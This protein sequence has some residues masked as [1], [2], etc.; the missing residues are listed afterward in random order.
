MVNEHMRRRK[1]WK[2]LRQKKFIKLLSVHTTTDFL[3]LATNSK[4]CSCCLGKL[5][6]WRSPRKHKKV[7]YSASHRPV[8]DNPAVEESSQTRT[9]V[10]ENTRSTS[11]TNNS[12]YRSTP[13]TLTDV[14]SVIRSTT[15]HSQDR[16][17]Q[18]M[19]MRKQ[20]LILKA[21]KEER[22][23]KA[24]ENRAEEL[25]INRMKIEMEREQHKATLDAQIAQITAS[26]QANMKMIEFLTTMTGKMHKDDSK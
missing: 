9:Q 5:P 18:I 21:Q 19:D 20:R 17:E 1:R 14:D 23:K 7:N 4:T 2:R 11:P 25:E 24:E 15:L 6:R 8:N 3:A 13:S 12:S 10:T 16:N 22:K 26:T